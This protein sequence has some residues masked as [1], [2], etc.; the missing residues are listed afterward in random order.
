MNMDH[1]PTDEELFCG[2]PGTNDVSGKKTFA[3]LYREK[4][5]AVGDYLST[6][7]EH[8]VHIDPDDYYDWRETE[9]E[10]VKRVRQ[11]HVNRA[12][13]V[14]TAIANKSFE[15]LRTWLSNT[16]RPGMYIGEF[17]DSLVTPYEI[18]DNGQSASYLERLW[19]NPDPK[20]A[21]K[22]KE[23]SNDAYWANCVM[24][25]VVAFKRPL[26]GLL[27][28]LALAGL[29][30]GLLWFLNATDRLGDD[31]GI[32]MVIIGVVV[33]LLWRAFKFLR[34]IFWTMQLLWGMKKKRTCVKK[35][36]D[37][38]EDCAVTVWPQLRLYELWY[39]ADKTIFP[40][41]MK[42]QQQ[43][44]KNAFAYYAEASVWLKKHS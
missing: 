16:I 9:E 21:E 30:G 37:T 20:L 43:E 2:L 25:P 8:D 29:L 41:L 40:E 18:K 24:H 1:L 15:K 26:L 27:I 38:M 36:C 33:F 35:Y 32:G 39:K 34:T 13:S 6:A 17:P 28:S 23:L 10:R 22:I 7:P 4:R 31:L 42:K 5:L 12:K 19:D 14:N 11:E 3:E 44:V